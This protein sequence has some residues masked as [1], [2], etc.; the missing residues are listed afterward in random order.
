MEHFIDIPA[1]NMP[2]LVI[3]GGGFGGIELAKKL[4]NSQIQIVLIDQNNYHTFQPLLYQV[5]TAGLEADSIVYPLRKIFRHQP[6]FYF[7]MA[8]ATQ[9]LAD[10]NILVTNI[11]KLQYNYLVIATGSTTNFFGMDNIEQQAMPMKSVAEAL[12]LRSLMLQ[13]FE[14]ALQITEPN[15]QASYLNFVV[16]G[17]GPTGVEMAGSLAELKKHVLPNDYPELDLKKMQIYLIEA[18]DRLLNGMSDVSGQK[19]TEFLQQFDVHVLLKT[20]VVN[21]DGT[22]VE[23]KEGTK[24]PSRTLI[25]SAGVMGNVVN[26]IDATSILR[27]NRIAVDEFCRIK[28]YQNV[29]AVGDV[30]CMVT[31]NYER[32][33]AMVAPVAIQ[34]GQLL[35]TN[36]LNL[37]QNKPLK[38]FKYTDKGSMATVGRNRAVVE[39]GK[40]KTQGFIAW[41]MWMAVHLMTLVGFRNKVVTFFNW[42]WSYINYDRGIRL[43]IRPYERKKADNV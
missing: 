21:Y 1:L 42:M 9:I 36:L 22:T 25:W 2:R 41:F 30:A 27:G 19:A 24:I 31:P 40:F 14:T 15:E 4:K 3:I 5:A 39:S 23:T 43:I 38:P 37:L 32:G 8:K 12:N 10:Q 13:N 20:A 7:R 18:S 34:Q 16:V 33:H 29:F 26:G 11:G 28:G 6:N 17:G 35:A